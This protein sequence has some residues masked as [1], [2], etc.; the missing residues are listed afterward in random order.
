MET[1]SLPLLFTEAGF[2]CKTPRAGARGWGHHSRATLR[3]AQAA[4]AMPKSWFPLPS[5]LAL[6]GNGPWAL[7]SAQGTAPVGRV[8]TGMA[9]SYRQ[10]CIFSPKPL[11]R[12]N[13]LPA[14]PLPSCS[15]LGPS[16]CLPSGRLKPSDGP[17]LCIRYTCRATTCWHCSIPVAM[18]SLLSQPS[19]QAPWSIRRCRGWFP[20]SRRSWDTMGRIQPQRCRVLLLWA[21]FPVSRF[22]LQGPCNGLRAL[23]PASGPLV[24]LSCH[25]KHKVGVFELSGKNLDAAP[26]MFI[27]SNRYCFFLPASAA[28]AERSHR[29]ELSHCPA[30]LPP[31]LAPSWWHSHGHGHTQPCPAPLRER[32]RN[33]QKCQWER[34]KPVTG[35]FAFTRHSLRSVVPPAG[36]T[37]GILLVGGTGAA[38]VAV[39]A[40]C[41]LPHLSEGRRFQHHSGVGIPPQRQPQGCCPAAPSRVC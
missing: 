30:A 11:H 6:Q 37:R 39:A 26:L 9:T 40:W 14:M 3:H 21:L 25:G 27:E 7:P 38:V 24:S 1:A 32:G 22:S 28:S 2:P 17:I 34:G 35:H 8:C 29:A 15:R 31:P 5:A 10:R 16:T 13:P 41:L 33:L 36:S 23:H 4:Q 20:P 19:L 12:A 18:A